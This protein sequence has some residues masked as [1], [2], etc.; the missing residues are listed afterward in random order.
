[1]ESARLADF[2][3]RLRARTMRLLAARL[4][5]DADR[6]VGEVVRSGDAAIVA[7]LEGDRGVTAGDCAAVYRDCVRVARAALVAERGDPTLV[8]LA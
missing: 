5:V 8:R 4:G 3:V 7:R 6:L 1:M 2:D